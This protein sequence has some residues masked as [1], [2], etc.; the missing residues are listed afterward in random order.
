MN[1]RRRTSST[2]E[3]YHRIWDTVSLVPEG[4]VATYGEIATAAGLPGRARL[5]GRAMAS[6]PED[7]AVPWHRVINA[8]GRISLP[9]KGPA[10]L[11]RALLEAEGI[12]LRQGRVDLRLYG[13]ETR[14]GEREE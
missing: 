1:P 13:W 8:A 14:A 9:P 3:L 2:V 4:R 10:E 5:V 6:L 12:E 11:Q 7:S